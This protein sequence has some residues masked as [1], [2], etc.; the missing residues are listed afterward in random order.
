MTGWKYDPGDKRFKHKWNKDVADFVTP[1]GMPV[2]KCPKSVGIDLATHLL[3]SGI[4]WHN[5]KIPK[6]YPDHIYNVYKGVIY[7]ATITLHGRSYHGY[8][9]KGRLPR[10][11]Y[12]KLVEIAKSQGYQAEFDE[13]VKVHI[14][15]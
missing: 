11:I 9:W 6:A 10:Q 4:E 7:K 14:E 3:N 13:W 8:P 15:K 2:G 12:D 5:P 1:D